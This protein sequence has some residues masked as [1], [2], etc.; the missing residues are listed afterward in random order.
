MD[1]ATAHEIMD[2]TKVSEIAENLVG[3]NIHKIEADNIIMFDYANRK[4]REYAAN[5]V[6]HCNMASEKF[7]Y[8]YNI[9]QIWHK[10]AAIIEER[11][12]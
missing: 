7:F 10:V 5:A 2:A 4:C 8:Y 3:I 11:Y 9:S 6:T 1:V 12:M